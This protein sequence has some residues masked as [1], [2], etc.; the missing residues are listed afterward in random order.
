[1]GVQT[2]LE[3]LEQPHQADIQGCE[4]CTILASDFLISWII[5]CSLLLLCADG[6]KVSLLSGLL[7]ASKPL[8]GVGC[9]LLPSWLAENSLF[10]SRNA[11]TRL[12]LSLLIIFASAFKFSYLVSISDS[13]RLRS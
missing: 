1:M 4:D 3:L 2:D 11:V 5:T 10:N 8:L 7:I 12:L 9:K 13:L 6:S